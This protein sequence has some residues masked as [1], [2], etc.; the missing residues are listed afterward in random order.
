MTE[1]VDAPVFE[2][3]AELFKALG[4]PVRV[5]VLEVLGTGEEL[6]VADLAAEVGVEAA[7]L[8]QQLGVLRRAGLVLSRREVTTVYYFIKD[9]L[10]I[11]LLAVARRLVISNLEENRDLLADLEAIEDRS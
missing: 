7:H 6:S 1:R 11:D 8:S 10:L 4:H 5:R 3:K 9:P 2:M